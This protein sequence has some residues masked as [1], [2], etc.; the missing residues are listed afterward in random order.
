[1]PNGEHKEFDETD[2]EEHITKYSGISEEMLATM[3]E[4]S[5]R[6]GAFLFESCPFCGGYP[7]DLEK[8]FP[9][10]D[11]LEAQKELRNHIKQH[12]QKIALFLPPYR[13]DIF[14]EDGDLRSSAITRRRSV[15]QN[16]LGELGEC[17]TV[18]DGQ[19]CKYKD[20][21]KYAAEDALAAESIAETELDPTGE[22]A[23]DFWPQIFGNSTLYNRS[24]VS[25][26]YYLSDKRLRPFIARLAPAPSSWA[27]TK[28]LR[29]RILDE[30]VE[31]ENE[32]DGSHKWIPVGSINSL[33]ENADVIAI[34]REARGAEEANWTMEYLN[35]LE[36]FVL[37]K[38]RRLFALLVWQKHVQLLDL[39]YGNDFDD[40][41][42]PVK[43]L[44]LVKGQKFDKQ[45]K[46][47]WT[48]ESTNSLITSEPKRIS[49]YKDDV[50]DEAIDDMCRYK[51]WIFF[52]PVF[53]EYNLAYVFS[54]ACIMPFLDELD[55]EKTNQTNFSVVRHFVIHSS[56]LK[57]TT[58]IVRNLF[59]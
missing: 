42:F 57:F 33:V 35:S 48:I 29:R 16:D 22:E 3:K 52:V 38:A 39:F 43:L 47:R 58:K 53:G 17:T 19:D 8:R 2:F 59:I 28:L 34:I 32:R 55:T 12:M 30:I 41:M 10:P 25:N 11:T 9:N 40:N 5:R 20:K 24:S 54:P 51:Q 18:C 50:D 23:A 56:H 46:P 45:S 21:G 31:A 36:K 37:L 15:N 27:A 1:M 14:D 13:E 44:K 4:A 49:Y 6:K 7:D 26:D